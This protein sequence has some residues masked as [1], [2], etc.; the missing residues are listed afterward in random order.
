MQKSGNSAAETETQE[1]S[2]ASDIVKTGNSYNQAITESDAKE[3]HQMLEENEIDPEQDNMF[4]V[5]DKDGP[6]EDPSVSTAETWDGVEE[7]VGSLEPHP[8]LEFAVVSGWDV[9]TLRRR[10]EDYLNDSFHL[11]GSMG[12]VV[13]VDGKKAQVHDIGKDD[14][15][16]AFQRIYSAAADEN[17]KIHPQGNSSNIVGSIKMEA[18]SPDRA[19][20]GAIADDV[21]ASEI[22]SAI[23]TREP[24]AEFFYTEADRP[25]VVFDNNEKNSRVLTEVLTN[26]FIYPGVRFEREDG[27]RI[28]LYR[29]PIDREDVSREQVY[30]VLEGSAPSNIK[31]KPYEDWGADLIRE[32][33]DFKGK[34][35]G[36]AT[37]GKDV[38][39]NEEYS[40]LIIGD[41][42]TDMAVPLE[43][44][45]SY[46]VAIE[47]SEAEHRSHEYEEWCEGED[48]IVVEDGVEFAGMFSSVM[49]DKREDWNHNV[50]GYNG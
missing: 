30:Q 35:Q 19:N 24:G 34:P 42:T 9:D 29:D 18:E 49:K 27:D 50:G 3:L 14:I 13:D 47:G 32:V 31:V 21:S 7:V 15:Y 6:L 41:S 17:L 38:F 39:S 46:F 1:P 33:D 5:F 2:A 36:V 44:P 12:T 26:D 40:T 10:R 37:L 8:G 22:Y 25:K 23:K 20:V 28:S 16:S 11:S 4:V 43:N 48:Y 45:D